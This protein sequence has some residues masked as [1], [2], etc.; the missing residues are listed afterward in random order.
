MA[1]G[2]PLVERPAR[3]DRRGPPGR[4]PAGAAG[5]P[6]LIRAEGLYAPEP[7]LTCPYPEHGRLTVHFSFHT[8]SPRSPPRSWRPNRDSRHAGRGEL[9]RLLRDLLGAQHA[10]DPD[11]AAEVREKLKHERWPPAASTVSGSGDW[12]LLDYLDVV[13]H[14]FTPEARAFYR[15]ESLWARSQARPSPADLE[16]TRFTVEEAE[17]LLDGWIRDAGRADGR[18]R[19]EM[20]PLR[21][22]WQRIVLAIGSNGGGLRSGCGAA[23]RPSSSGC[24]TSWTRRPSRSREQG[25]Q[26]KEWNAGWSN[27]RRWWRAGRR[28]CAGTWARSGSPSG[29]GRGRL[30]RA[31]AAVSAGDHLDEALAAEPRHTRALLA[32]EPAQEQLLRARDAYLASHAETGPPS[33]GRLIGGAEDGDPG[34]RGRRRSRARRSPRR[35]GPSPPAA[36]YARAWPRSRPGERARGRRR[37][38]TRA[39]AFE[40]TG[41]AMAALAAGDA[42]AYTA[43]WPRS[44]PTSRR[45]TRTVR[46]GGGRH[47]HGAG[48]A[49]RPAGH[50]RR[51]DSPMPPAA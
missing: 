9:H 40:R 21:V 30:R 32:G 35:R 6:E 19:A 13:L 46:R 16:R 22:R 33:W 12:I 24:P 41:R 4:R 3:R 17:A 5:R 31:A 42:A 43:R 26:V 23:A 8:A 10:P 44:S 27:S 39:E 34:R 1:A 18:A 49:G 51:P 25:V 14:V 15:L 48:A 45:A 20:Q 29:T 47:G 28:C 36:A 37:C 2:R 7:V 38:W 50:G 11:L